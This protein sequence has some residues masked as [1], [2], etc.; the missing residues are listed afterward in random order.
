MSPSPT[1]A[2][3]GS[4]YDRMSRCSYILAVLSNKY[5]LRVD[6][7]SCRCTSTSPH[8]MLTR[9]VVAVPLLHPISC[10]R[11]T[12]TSPHI[13]LTRQVVAVPLLHP[14]SCSLLRWTT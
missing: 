4:V 8:I 5:E 3:L 6:P 12:S 13:M 11:C 9:Q 10:C 1:N 2:E 7:S 14:I